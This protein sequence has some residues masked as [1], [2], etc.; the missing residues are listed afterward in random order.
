VNELYKANWF[1]S[2]RIGAKISGYVSY[3]LVLS[4]TKRIPDTIH[5]ETV[6]YF[7][8]AL[9]YILPCISWHDKLLLRKV[10][11]LNGALHYF[12]GS[13][14][15]SWIIF[16]FIVCNCSVNIFVLWRKISMKLIN[17][18]LI[19][20]FLHIKKRKVAYRAMSRTQKVVWITKERPVQ[21][22]PFWLPSFSQ[23]R[24]ELYSEIK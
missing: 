18:Q 17:V 21:L 16:A 22:C 6:A 11:Y 15:I 9:Q 23:L 24:G 7:I 19:Q 2:S 12:S 20:N 13:A 14:C 3:H 8:E 10:I 5:P 1:F 4:V